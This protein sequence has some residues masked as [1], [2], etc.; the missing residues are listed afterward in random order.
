[1]KIKETL[2]DV[3]AKEFEKGMNYL[4]KG[5]ISE[6]EKCFSELLK[7][8]PDFEEVAFVL[9]EIKESRNW[10]AK[11]F[12]G[13]CGKLLIPETDYPHLA[14]SSYC[15]N[16]GQ[17]INISKEEYIAIFEFLTKI[18]A[19]GVFLP[20]LIVFCSIPFRQGTMTGIWYLWNPLLD[21]IFSAIS[22]T[23][24]V[25]IILL[26]V[27]DP[28]GFS[29]KNIHDEIYNFASG[30]FALLFFISA[31]LLFMVIYIYFLFLLTPFL[32]IHRKGFWKS[33]K[34]QKRLLLC[35]LLFFGLIIVIRI[36]AGVF[37]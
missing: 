28:W 32:A 29:L 18:V 14:F 17:T 10:S 25:I 6:A 22:F 12:C 1:M 4:R 9:K 8:K 35:T 24:I 16:C 34:H 15:P 19:F 33:G 20:I 21:G 36:G 27:N 23:P 5:K 2:G 7:W 11:N 30:N 31:L 26:L 13:N 3:T 37:Y